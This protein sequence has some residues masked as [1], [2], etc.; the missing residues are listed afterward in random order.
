MLPV[1]AASCGT[2]GC[3][4]NPTGQG[5]FVVWPAARQGDACDFAQ[6][7]NETASIIDLATPDN[8]RLT[9]KVSGVNPGH[10]V[11][12][13]TAPELIALREYVK[14]S[15]KTFADGGGGV[16]AQPGASPYSIA[17]F[18]ATILPMFNGCAVSGC[19][20][21]P[22]GQRTFNV[23]A[24]AT[25][26]ADV[27][28]NF[29]AISG[30]GNL[31]DPRNSQVYTQATV[32]HASGRSV[33]IDATQ[34]A[35][36][37]AWIEDAKTNAGSNPTPTCAPL[38]S[39]NVGTFTQ[40]VLPIL[41]GQIDLNNANQQGNGAGCMSTACHG[42]DRG[43]G[44]L[45][46]VGDPSTI[47]SNFACF[48]DL[49]SPS[50][51]EILA[52][53]TDTAGCRLPQHPGQDILG[54]ANDLNYQRILGFLFG[55]KSTVSPFDFAFFVR[56]IN[57]IYDDIQSV[58]AGARGISCTEATACHGSSSGSSAPGGSDFPII[59]SASGID[60]L[61]RNF[62]NST[63]FTT[64]LNPTESSLFLYPT[65][66]IAN[67]GAHAF[68]TGQNHPGGLDFAPDSEL[69][70]TILQWAGGLRPDG[71]GFQRNWLVAGTFGGTQIT[72]GIAGEALLEPSI[73]DRSGGTFDDINDGWD[74]LFSNQALVD[75][76]QALPG[77]PGS[78][79]FAYAAAYIT[80]TAARQIEA[81]L[82]IKTDNPVAIFV[83]GVFVTDNAVGGGAT[84]NLILKAAGTKSPATRVVIKLL[85]RADDAAFAFSAKLADRI[86][87][88]LLT[89]ATG[90]LVVTLGKNGGI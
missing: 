8:S 30:R 51:S 38:D 80:N 34:A 28:A 18:K 6:S 1:L 52:C 88:A 56:K 19:H 31:K 60:R 75:L 26:D 41:A 16:I 24:N 76:N 11:F 55:T 83:N 81:R 90:E 53:P 14:A 22:N 2:A 84:A 3:H 45:S 82:E 33:T 85:Q 46:L 68:A 44:K 54:G 87:G 69:A 66:E 42:I 36:L 10:L 63:S 5:G 23:I 67:V 47:L 57:P 61:T 89:D 25:S 70:L 39:F 65:D 58:E 73:F 9:A 78:G 17:T 29:L 7:F 43:P 35:A 62:V 72:D 13:E 59:P 27:T 50:S 40:E 49:T 20:L 48:V 74:G 71:Q 37:L 32:Q 12:A 4:I 64:F 15:A 77:A 86:S 79:R 21:A